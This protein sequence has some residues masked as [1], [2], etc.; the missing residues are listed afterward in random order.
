MK[1]SLVLIGA[2]VHIS[3]T[4][5]QS[6]GT[7][8]ATANMSMERMFHTATLLTNG[9]VPPSCHRTAEGY[10]PPGPAKGGMN[11]QLGRVDSELRCL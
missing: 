1:T 7:F 5:A 8:I 3:I 9:K 4:L 6:P 10:L 11:Q 2:A